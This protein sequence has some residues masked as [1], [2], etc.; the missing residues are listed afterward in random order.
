MSRRTVFLDGRIGPNGFLSP[1]FLIADFSEVNLTVPFVVFTDASAGG[2]V[3]VH[4]RR[5]VSLS[6]A[7]ALLW[8]DSGTP[9]YQAEQIARTT[10]LR[11]EYF[12]WFPVHVVNNSRNKGPHLI[13][14]IAF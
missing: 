14:P 9:Y 7:T 11:E 13:E 10:S 1:Q 4:D 5:P 8:L 12:E 6:L 2:M 3:D